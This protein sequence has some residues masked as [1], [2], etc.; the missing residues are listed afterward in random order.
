MAFPTPSRTQV[1]DDAVV[2]TIDTYIETRRADVIFNR[3]LLL[4]AL[5]NA[6]KSPG[7]PGK[8]PNIPGGRV[9][10][11]AARELWLPIATQSSTNTT[12]F[13]HTD[14]LTTNLDPVG[15]VQR[16]NYAYYTDFAGISKQE[17]W[18]NSG[19]EAML[20][21]MQ[22]R[23]DMVLRSLSSVIDVDLHAV[24][25]GTTVDA[26][27]Q[28]KRVLGLQTLIASVPTSGVI[29][30]I[31]RNLNTFQR[32]NTS[33]DVADTF[34]NVGMDKLRVMWTTV[35]GNAGGDPP[36]VHLTTPTLFNAY[37][38]EAEDK[39]LVTDIKAADLGVPTIPY[40]GVP[41]LYG[42]RVKSGA[43]Y[44]L[45]LG[46]CYLLMPPGADFMSERY[47]SP[48]N[49]AIEKLWRIFVG[50]QWGF[51]RYDRQGVIFGFTDA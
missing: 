15:T 14:T 31:D 1:L 40:K 51:S 4:G 41:V 18:E 2:S 36:N 9:R 11:R 24:G 39:H 28:N 46:Y 10:R 49:Q 29:W 47:D 13:T 7:T 42:S 34:A 37:C 30:N 3:N 48:P 50:L 35:S 21:R 8:L 26:N 22:D 19:P 33:G 32:N 25:D 20:D 38:R 44:M 27:L 43:W 45:N 17:A 16:F 23:V 12:P 6:E 5:W